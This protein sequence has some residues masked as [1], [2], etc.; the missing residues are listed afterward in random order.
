MN[1]MENPHAKQRI[2]KDIS[3]EDERIQVT[4]YVKEIDAEKIILDDT[5]DTLEVDISEVDHDLKEKDLINVMGDLILQTS[6]EMILKALII[7]DKNKL[8]FKYYLKLYEL[9]K[10]IEY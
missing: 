6:G 5:M 10:E 1:G 7:Q 2:I 3:T 9:K 4:G 8:N